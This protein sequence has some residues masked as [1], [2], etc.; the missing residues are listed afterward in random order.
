MD[1]YDNMFMY[2]ICADFSHTSHDPG[3]AAGKQKWI[4]TN[5]WP[6]LVENWQKTAG[7][8]CATPEGTCCPDC[9]DYE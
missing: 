7:T 2:A 6:I 4:G 1:G 3:L 5:D 9:L 8:C